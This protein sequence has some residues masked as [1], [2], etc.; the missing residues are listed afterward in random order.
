MNVKTLCMIGL[1]LALLCGSAFAQSDNMGVVDTLTLT[2]EKYAPNK[3][4]VKADFWN[5]EEIAAFDIPLKYTAGMTKLTV[6]SVS[7]A[8]T[9]VDYFAQKYQQVDTTGQM[10]HFGGLAYIGSD[11]PPLAPGSGEIGRVYISTA[12]G[13]N[14]DNIVVDT[15]FFAPNNKMLFVDRNAKAIIPAL[16]IQTAKK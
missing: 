3:W 11:K 6:D 15:V 9:R 14:A 5:D 10:M 13:A 12:G 16:I 8:G 4:V 2:V 7:H 1:T